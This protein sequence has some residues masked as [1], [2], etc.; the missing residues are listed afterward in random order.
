LLSFVSS[1]ATAFAMAFLFDLI[2]RRLEQAVSDEA[3]ARAAA[4]AAQTEREA[5]LTAASQA[6]RLESLGRLAGGVAHDFNNAIGIVSLCADQLDQASDAER[7]ELIEE[8]R[9]ASRGAAA[10][11]RQLLSF[12][13][14]GS[15]PGSRAPVAQVLAAMATSLRRL[16]PESITIELESHTSLGVPLSVGDLEQVVLNLCLNARDAMPTGGTLRLAAAETTT[17]D[18][19]PA[20]RVS[21]HDSGHGMDDAV[22]LRAI[23]PFFTTKPM[24]EGSGLGLTMVTTI[25][26]QAG[27]QIEVDSHPGAGTAV[28]LTLPAIALAITLDTAAHSPTA[29]ASRQR[30]LVLEDEEQL[31]RLLH[32]TLERLGFEVTMT[33]TVQQALDTLA[34]I[35]VPDLL[36]TDAVL[37][38]GGPSALI[39]QY[40]DRAPTGPVLVCSGYVPSPDLI[41]GI[42]QAAYAFL[43][44]PFGQRELADAIERARAFGLAQVG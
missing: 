32:R 14:Q 20:V 38:D 13:R 11:T 37:P 21:V 26:R 9:R 27:G 6:Q 17:A 39:A 4:A 28:T 44:K 31:Q 3:A 7:Q 8:I 35:D 43:A 10:T 5:A 25:V 40:R 23:D 22:R 33:G 29:Q 36:F 12:A 16:F 18:G 19:Q 24:N 42:E 41:A 15:A 1:S 30:V 2:I 34:A